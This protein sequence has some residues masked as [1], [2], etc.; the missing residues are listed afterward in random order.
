[1]RVGGQKTRI[2]IWHNVKTGT[3]PLNEDIVEPALW[4]KTW[5]EMSMHLG[6][7]YL[8]GRVLSLTL[9]YFSCRYFSVAG[10]DTSYWLVVKGQTYDIRN[11]NPDFSDSDNT[12]IEARVQDV[13]A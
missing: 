1:M 2:E 4:K 10:I 11:V 9:F 7:E 12:I 6:R 3:S 13:K 8:E 5:A